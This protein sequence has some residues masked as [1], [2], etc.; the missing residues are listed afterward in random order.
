MTSQKGFVQPVRS[1]CSH[2]VPD[3]MAKGNDKADY[4]TH[5]NITH[6]VD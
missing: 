2:P 1:V 3:Y 6:P 5:T 4:T